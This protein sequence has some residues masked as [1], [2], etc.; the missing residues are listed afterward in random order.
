M[1]IYY[2][3]HICWLINSYLTKIISCLTPDNIQLSVPF[4]N[5][6]SLCCTEQYVYCDSF[7]VCRKKSS[8]NY[9]VFAILRNVSLDAN[10]R[11]VHYYSKM[12]KKNLTHKY[13]KCNIKRKHYFF[14]DKILQK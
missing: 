14:C 5:N 11:R 10:N 6:V 3:C 7:Y 1:I 8:T 13:Y 12:Y 4:L 2:L 9:G